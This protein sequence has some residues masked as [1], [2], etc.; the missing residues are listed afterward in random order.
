MRFYKAKP[1]AVEKY[2]SVDALK[3]TVILIVASLRMALFLAQAL[4]LVRRYPFSIASSRIRTRARVSGSICPMADDLL[5]YAA[6]IVTTSSINAQE[7][8]P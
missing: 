8:L 1:I 4:S 7:A 3:S 6:R 2:S 5:P